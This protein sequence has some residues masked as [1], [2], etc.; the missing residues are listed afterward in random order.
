MQTEKEKARQDAELARLPI[1]TAVL[2]RGA[3]GMG[4]GVVREHITQEGGIP[5]IG[6]AK[7]VVYFWDDFGAQPSVLKTSELY[8]APQHKAIRGTAQNIRHVYNAAKNARR[9]YVMALC[10]EAE[11]FGA[12]SR[13]YTLLCDHLTTGAPLPNSATEGYQTA[14]A[15]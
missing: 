13:A 2:V 15:H 8:K 7:A 14:V 4:L 1:G 12:G 5:L 10:S 9:S 3:E 11:R 6:W